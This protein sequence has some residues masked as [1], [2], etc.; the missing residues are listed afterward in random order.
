MKDEMADGRDGASETADTEHKTA[1]DP[2]TAAIV[3]ELEEI[4]DA[5]ERL[6]QRLQAGRRT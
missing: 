5:L 1:G 6:V 4:A 3:A 2:A